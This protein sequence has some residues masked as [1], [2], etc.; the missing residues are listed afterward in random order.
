MGLTP[1][2]AG[3]RPRILEGVRVVDMS[4]VLAGPLCAQILADFGAEV[5]KLERPEVGDDTR[6]WEPSFT[7]QT[8]P[9]VRESAYFCSVNR[10]K[11]SVTLDFTKLEGAEIVR[12]L[13]KEADVLV[14]N[15]KV[16]TLERYGLG[17]E[18]LHTLNPRLI[19]VSVTGFGQT[20]PYRTRAGYDTIIQALGGLMSITGQ[21]AEEAG[22]GPLRAG[23]PVIDLMTGIYGALGILAALRHRD[24]TGLGQHIDL[25]LMDVQVSALTYFATNY[26]ASGVVPQRMGNANP[27]TFPSGTFP[28]ADRELMLIVGNDAQFQRFC[29]ALGCPELAQDERFLTSPL[30]VRNRVVLTSKISPV[31]QSQPS[32]Y[33]MRELEAIGVPCAPINDLDGVFADPQVC[34]RDMVVSV[35]HPRL[36]EIPVVRNPL[37][38]SRTP[39]DCGSAPPVLGEHTD[40]TLR[41][42]IGLSADQI[43]R[44]RKLGIV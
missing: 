36:G 12:S 23:L 39:T 4:R 28:S 13:V 15:Y 7:S 41:T 26:L 1:S 29:R 16:G 19:Y 35:E 37:R 14:E 31:L 8:D 44:L 27:V 32:S 34:E 22:A 10:G 17:Y 43:A 20:G 24:S 25:A 40:E 21:P 42:A 18:Q 6:S 11:R 38:M 3:A 33:W 5:T 30:R 9:S 2:P